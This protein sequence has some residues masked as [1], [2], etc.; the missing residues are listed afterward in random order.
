MTHFLLIAKDHP[1]QLERRMKARDAHIALGDKLVAENKLIYGGAMIDDSGNMTGSMLVCN[2]ESRQQLDDWLKI[3]PYV[4]E[5]VWDDI[6]ITEFRIGPSF[7][8]K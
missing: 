5:N 6:E 8:G 7:Q 3:E 1:N 4:T 2:F